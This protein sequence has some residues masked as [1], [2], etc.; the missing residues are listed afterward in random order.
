MA[1]SGEDITT[2]TQIVNQANETQYNRLS[3]KL[4]LTVSPVKQNLESH[5][6]H[7]EKTDADMYGKLNDLSTGQTALK[8][9]MKMISVFGSALLTIATGTILA[10]IKGHL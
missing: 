7:D 9:N 1:L 5:I 4:E 2:I 3:E 6:A 10:V 8:S